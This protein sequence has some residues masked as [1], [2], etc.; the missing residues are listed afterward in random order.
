M[1]ECGQTFDVSVSETQKT[2]LTRKDNLMNKFFAVLILAV[3]IS[4]FLFACN[5]DGFQRQSFQQSTLY[6]MLEPA[7]KIDNMVITTGAEDATPLWAF[8]LP[9]VKS[10]H[11]IMVDCGEV[12]FSR[13]AIGHTFGVM[14]LV[15]EGTD[16]SEL[17]WEL[18]LDGHPIDLSAFGNYSFV[19]PD[20]APNPS[21]I[22]E[23]FR[24]T[25]VWDVVLENPAKGA[26]VLYG[27]A[28]SKDETY[29]W[30]VDFTIATS[31]YK[32]VYILFRTAESY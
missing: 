2:T 29:I 27:R 28:Q 15:P 26:H 20:L 13:L 32:E 31:D 12:S 18:S 7:D 19:H 22:K 14:N 4:P 1:P 16:W 3:L 23:V 30:I 11:L 25:K 8:C 24:S 10:D 9:T 6:A 5:G 17:N 21:L